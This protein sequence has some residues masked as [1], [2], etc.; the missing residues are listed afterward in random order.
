MRVAI[1]LVESRLV[2]QEISIDKDEI[3]YPTSHQKKIYNIPHFFF[4]WLQWGGF[5]H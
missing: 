3:T 1:L 2:I 5:E 4:R